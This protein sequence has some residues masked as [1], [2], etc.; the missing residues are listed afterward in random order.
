MARAILEGERVQSLRFGPTKSE[1]K[2]RHESK[3]HPDVAEAWIQR[4]IAA[5]G[6]FAR[7]DRLR[8]SG[9]DLALAPE[10][11]GQRDRLLRDL[12]SRGFS[13]PSQR[14]LLEALGGRAETAELLQLCLA[15]ESI[16]RLPGDILLRGTLIDELRRRVREYFRAQPEMTVAALKDVL[17]VSRK[18]GVPL[19]EYLDARQWTQRRGD[20][21]VAGRRLEE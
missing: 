17:G 8:R 2:S 12:E 13:G 18:Q 20:V 19:L 6:L 11:Q 21:R 7:G 1:L 5:G 16:V 3:V 4:E 15:E 9:P 14:E 10:L